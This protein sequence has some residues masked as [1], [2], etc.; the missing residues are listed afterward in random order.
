MTETEQ[1]SVSHQERGLVS[2]DFHQKSMKTNPVRVLFIKGTTL[3]RRTRTPLPH[4][5]PKTNATLQIFVSVITNLSPSPFL[6]FRQQVCDDKMMK[7]PS[8]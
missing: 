4:G 1:T 6:N 7:K 5:S 8:K 3:K 2:S